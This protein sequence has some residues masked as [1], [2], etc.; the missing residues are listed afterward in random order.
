MKKKTSL[1]VLASMACCA[2][3]VSCSAD[4]DTPVY[5]FDSIASN[6]DE[7]DA[8]TYGEP[9]TLTPPT[10]DPA[11]D[12]DNKLKSYLPTDS[13]AFYDASGNITGYYGYIDLGLAEKWAVCNVGVSPVQKYPAEG[14]KSF[15][16]FYTPD[17]YVSR[18]EE[19]VANG[20]AEINAIYSDYKKQFVGNAQDEATMTFGEFK[21]MVQNMSGHLSLSSYTY[22]GRTAATVYKT[23]CDDYRAV[24]DESVTAFNQ[25]V[26]DYESYMLSTKYAFLQQVGEYMLW[27]YNSNDDYDS[28]F[29]VM[30]SSP[31]DHY[32]SVPTDYAGNAAYDAATN[33]WGT[34][35]ATPS[36]GIMQNLMDNC[37]LSYTSVGD[38]TGITLTAT[39]GK[40][41][42]FPDNQG[43]RLLTSTKDDS[44]PYWAYFYMADIS[45]GYK[46]TR[47][48][49]GNLGKMLRPV[50]NK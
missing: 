11:D 36:K 47:A 48:Y 49:N 46:I 12:I 26:K 15:A 24:Y 23:M 3:F 37:T 30:A 21:T 5:I 16:D 22:N 45:G 10:L 9:E 7:P 41:L 31:D 44:N 13:V 1:L 38:V 6:A 25:A 40:T 33:L 19:I 28:H 35:W 17:P 27:G 43:V 14:Y 34:S 2:L 20:M 39:S 29:G 4:D 18:M 32:N 42:F 50:L 8:L